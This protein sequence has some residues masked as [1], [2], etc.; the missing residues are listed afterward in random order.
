MR[1]NCG[2]IAFDKLVG[3][4]HGRTGKIS[5][6]TMAKMAQDNDFLLYPMRVPVSDLWKFG[7]EVILHDDGHFETVETDNVFSLNSN[8]DSEVYIL[9]PELDGN[10]EYVIEDDEAKTVKGSGFFDKVKKE[11]SRAESKVRKEAGRAESSVRGEL[12]RSEGKLRAESQREGFKTIAPL[13]AG[14]VPGIGP[15]LA[16]GLGAY[17]GYQGGGGLGGAFTGALRGGAT[18]ALGAGIGGAVGGAVGSAGTGLSGGLAGAGTGFGAGVSSYGSALTSPFTGGGLSTTSPFAAGQAA[19]A[20]PSTITG[21]LGQ[22]SQGALTQGGGF[23]PG[24]P[25]QASAATGATAAGGTGLAG[26][27]GGGGFGFGRLGQLAGLGI[28]GLALGKSASIETPEFGGFDIATSIQRTR[29]PAFEAAQA[30]LVQGLGREPGTFYSGIAEPIVA[31]Q[32]EGMEQELQD[33]IKQVQNRYQ[34]AGRGNS[35][36][37]HAEIADL[38]TQH[39]ENSRKLRRDVAAD[40]AVREEQARSAMRGLGVQ[41]DEQESRE[42]LGLTQM[43]AEEAALKYGILVDDVNS[44]R[45]LWSQIGSLGIQY[46]LGAFTP[47]LPGQGVA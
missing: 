39:M 16:A 28:G 26:S 10:E 43:N 35:N 33:Q 3:R 12:S 32:V 2:V 20:G 37:M 42:L 21:A 18:G 31:T 9:T 36:E 17:S 4:L 29:G 41:I 38:Q 19:V 13:V 24:V 11:L 25:G 7:S 40:L 30:D 44:Y 14:L 23:V 15:F 1:N 47:R 27:T 46:G 45:N 6:S 22:A 8:E 5:L 34:A